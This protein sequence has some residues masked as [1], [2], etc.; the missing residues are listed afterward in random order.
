MACGKGLRAGF[1]ILALAGVL[2][3]GGGCGPS[4]PPTVPV[5]GTV[6]LDGKP[7]D[8]VEVFFA[9]EDVAA[10]TVTDSSGNF[11][12]AKGAG[13]GLNKVWLRKFVGGDPALMGMDAEQLAAA[14]S[15]GGS[16]K[17]P[18]PLFPPKYSDPALTVLTFAVP[19]GGT[20]DAKIE[21]SSK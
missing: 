17:V 7:V 19:E 4:G 21:A 12:F 10:T 9:T 1:S 3:I 6:L 18:K 2:S 5:S 11:A 13:P 15:A 20:S 14:N 8:G 16:V